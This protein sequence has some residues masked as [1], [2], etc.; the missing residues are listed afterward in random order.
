MGRTL[1]IL[2]IVAAVF[3]ALVAL[4][5]V[6]VAALVFLPAALAGAVF[7]FLERRLAGVVGGL[8]VLVLSVPAVFG[9][10]GNVATEDSGSVDFGIAEDV[11]RA[12]AVVALLA[13][14]AATVWSRWEDAEPRWLAIAGLSVT[15]LAAV[16]AFVNRADLVDQSNGLTLFVGVL[17]LAALSPMV[18]LLRSPPS[19]APS[20]P[21]S[22]AA[23]PAGRQRP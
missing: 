20:A 4:V 22:P 9:L 12:L 16:L 1:P 17:C 2:G 7:L 8:V 14:P 15:G 5:L 11:G 6:D 21:A 18:P 10:L 3:S 19:P 13:V 23:P